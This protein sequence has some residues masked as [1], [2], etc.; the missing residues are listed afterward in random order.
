MVKRFDKILTK[1]RKDNTYKFALARFLIDYAQKKT[2]LEIKSMLENN[3]GEIIEFRSIAKSFLKYYWHQ[4]IKYKIWQNSNVRVPP[5]IVKIIEKIFGNENSVRKFSDIEEVNRKEAETQ[6][7][8]ECFEEVIHRFQIVKDE[9]QDLPFYTFD[10]RSRTISVKPQALEFFKNNYYDLY[11]SIILQ[12]S[13][14]LEKLNPGLPM[15]ISKIEKDDV[16]RGALVKYRKM[17]KPHFPTCF[18]CET[19][20][21]SEKNEVAVDHF[22]PWVY[23]LEDEVWN[24]VL[25]CKDCNTDKSDWRYPEKFRN[26]IVN[27]NEK[28]RKQIGDMDKSLL[29]LGAKWKEAIELHYLNCSKRYN[30]DPNTQVFECN[31]CHCLWTPRI[32]EEKLL[33][34]PRC[35]PKLETRT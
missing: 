29:K 32:K 28:Y 10:K 16:K 23:I 22:I 11:N 9:P 27:R 20:L 21:S 26:K 17:L 1:G 6:I 7:E 34:C 12:W 30:L 13:K 8:K 25:A 4:I 19:L 18:Y 3:Q 31:G 5:R 33:L 15:L 24:L 14:F 2:E 35:K